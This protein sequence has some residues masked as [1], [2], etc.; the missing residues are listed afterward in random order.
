[1]GQKKRA[2]IGI[3]SNIEREKNFKK[4]YLFLRKLF[5]KI[6]FSKIFETAP[7][8]FSS[9]KMFFNSVAKF[10]T[11]KNPEEIKTELKKVEKKVGRKK[12]RK[13]ASPREIDLDLLLFGNKII[14]NTVFESYNT[15]C[16]KGF[17]GKKEVPK[18]LQNFLEEKNRLAVPKKKKSKRQ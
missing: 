14:D 17:L 6:I 9:K 10:Y 1:M 16:L 4:A 12:R 7:Q 2:V 11:K 15:V 8:G 18:R 3:G 13:K 5:P